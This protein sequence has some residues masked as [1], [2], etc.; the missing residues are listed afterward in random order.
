MLLVGV[1]AVEALF[2]VEMA[3][4]VEEDLELVLVYLLPLELLIR[5]PL[6][7]EGPHL[8]PDKTQY[9]AIHLQKLH[10]QGEGGAVIK[11]QIT[12]EPEGLAEGLD[13]L[14]VVFPVAQ[15]TR[16]V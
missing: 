14:E 10:P 9:L 2:L 11:I 4:V 7:L 8:L 13:L 3:V 15:E 6:G 1:V 5:S 12:Q 16:L